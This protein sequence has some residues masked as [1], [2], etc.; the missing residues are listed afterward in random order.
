VRASRFSTIQVLG[1]TYSVPSRLLGVAV[2]VRVRAVRALVDAPLPPLL[3]TPTV[4][5]AAYD[6]LLPSRYA[7][8]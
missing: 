2:L 7:R 8:A 3:A 6:Q 4:S 5:L 1:N